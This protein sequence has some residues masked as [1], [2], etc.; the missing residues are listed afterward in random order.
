MTSSK[1]KY[2]KLNRK[3]AT[4]VTRYS[5]VKN[6]LKKEFPDCEILTTTALKHGARFSNNKIIC[7]E[8]M[9]DGFEHFLVRAGGE[10]LDITSLLYKIDI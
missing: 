7:V 1:H 9:E 10:D 2:L 6:I 3:D 4:I 8:P 5:V